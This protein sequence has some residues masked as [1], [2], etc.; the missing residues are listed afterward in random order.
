[1]STE[2]A[3]HSNTPS[4]GLPMTE[5]TFKIDAS[6]KA[7]GLASLRAI[8]GRLARSYPALVQASHELGE[9]ARLDIT[10]AIAR[11]NSGRCRNQA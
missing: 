10:P 2:C 5:L 11:D 4:D 9:L 3:S 1:M 8:G 6:C 7:V